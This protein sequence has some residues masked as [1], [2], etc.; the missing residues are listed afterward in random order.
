[1]KPLLIL[2]ALIEAGTGLG[3]LAAPSVLAQLLL[4]APLDAPAA[5]TVARV[6]GAG[7]LALGI[8]CWL[9]AHDTFSCAARGV[10]SAMAV[11]NLGAVLILGAAGIQG[12]P[13]G[14]ALWL[15]VGLH[16]AMAVWCVASLLGKKTEIPN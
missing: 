16:A 8:A 9:A 12:Q 11:Y 2:T 3:L 10:V 7:L 5:L 13:V 6:A 15:V 14:I 1:M 4:G